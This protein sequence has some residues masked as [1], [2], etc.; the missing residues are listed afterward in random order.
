MWQACMCCEYRRRSVRW[1]DHTRSSMSRTRRRRT[2]STCSEHHAMSCRLSPTTSCSSTTSDARTC[3]P[4][5]GW[6]SCDSRL[7]PPHPHLLLLY[8]QLHRRQGLTDSELPTSMTWTRTTTSCILP[9]CCIVDCLT[10][11]ASRRPRP[12][13]AGC[14]GV[15]RPLPPNKMPKITFPWKL[16]K[17]ENI[18][19]KVVVIILFIPIRLVAARFDRTLIDT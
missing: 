11:F 13:P 10:D 15:K 3:R 1:H 16:S 17:T 6:W 4:L 2:P 5:C 18:E 9:L 19:G 14:S 7:P 12:W 8:H